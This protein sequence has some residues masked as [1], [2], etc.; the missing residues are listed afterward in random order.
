MRVAGLNVPKEHGAWAML[1]VPFVLGVLVAGRVTLATLWTLLAMT[2]LFF[3]RETLWRLRRARAKQRPA[4]ALGPALGV[5][6]AV[7]VSCGSLLVFSHALLW[8]VPLGVAALLVL[9]FNLE[10]TEQR[11]E[12][13][14]ASQLVAIAGFAMAAPAAYYASRAAWQTTAIW[15]WGLS[16]AYFAS[17]VFHVK[18]VVLGVQPQRRAAFARMRA[19]AAAYHAVVAVTLGLLVARATLPPLVLVAFVPIL[20]RAVWSML[21]RPVRLNLRRIG[22]LEIFYS[23]N[24]LLFVTLAFRL[25]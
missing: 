22:I 17:S 9:V 1:Y 14:I 5:E 6:A 24:F 13:S 25:R 12:R 19:I 10:R 2:A 3:A 23:L 18:S 7:V 8:F 15:L 16:W 4:A 20:G 11:E 21:R